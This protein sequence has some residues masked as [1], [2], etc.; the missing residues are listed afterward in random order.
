MKAHEAAALLGG[1][2]DSFDVCV[3]V[4]VLTERER[5]SNKRDFITTSV[6]GCNWVLAAVL[7]VKPV[8]LNGSHTKRL[9]SFSTHVPTSSWS[10]SETTLAWL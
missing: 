6:H 5:A 1:N 2:V 3:C 9:L 10:V 7:Q 4:C 8:V